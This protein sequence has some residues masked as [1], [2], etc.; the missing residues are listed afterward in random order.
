MKL[1]EIASHN[2]PNNS[3]VQGALRELC[4][5]GLKTPPPSH[6]FTHKSRCAA[7]NFAQLRTTKAGRQQELFQTEPKPTGK[8]MALIGKRRTRPEDYRRKVRVALEAFEPA[9]G[10][11]GSNLYSLSVQDRGPGEN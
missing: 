2:Y 5:G 1:R 7:H 6:N 10:I 3:L 9:E 8:H 4:G 11:G